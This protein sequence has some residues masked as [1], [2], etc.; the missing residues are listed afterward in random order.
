MSI[1]P[2]LTCEPAFGASGVLA[3][4]RRA[5]RHKAM[6]RPCCVIT[7]T[8]IMIGLVRNFSVRGAM[9]ELDAG[10]AVGETISYFWEENSH[11]S[12]RIVWREGV[13]F[14]VEHLDPVPAE[15][16]HFAARSVRIPCRAEAC[17][18]IGGDIYTAL[19]KNIS[20]GGM[21]VVGLPQLVPGSLLSV[22]FCGLEFSSVSVR[23]SGR[24]STGLRFA[25]RMSREGLAQILL[26][27]RF[28]I[29]SLE[30]EKGIPTLGK[31]EIEGLH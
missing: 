9:I 3:D 11:M 1:L 15:K 14:G 19:V 13:S 12:A 8:R 7:S 28:G 21:R 17:C 2:D 27:E 23:W 16:G 24:L 6:Y 4:R 25:E 5:E 30:F 22:S 18:W 20:L 29:A 31:A 26:D 10:L